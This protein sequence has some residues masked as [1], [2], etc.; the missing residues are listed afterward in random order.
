MYGTQ[1][2]QSIGVLPFRDVYDLVDFIVFPSAFVMYTLYL[3]HLT[4]LLIGSRGLLKDTFVN[5]KR[6]LGLIATYIVITTTVYEYV[7]PYIRCSRFKL[8]VSIPLIYMGLT[9]TRQV[10][11]L[12]TWNR[13]EAELIGMKRMVA[14]LG[15]NMFFQWCLQTQLWHGSA[16][17][18]TTFLILGWSTCLLLAPRTLRPPLSVQYNRSSW[19]WEE[20]RCPCFSTKQTKTK[21]S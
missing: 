4:S 5:N 3:Y 10:S 7:N 9:L 2:V 6:A 8:D 19:D 12:L 15:V 16:L 21:Q 18:C 13:R 20:V 1:V 11:T 17:F 14:S